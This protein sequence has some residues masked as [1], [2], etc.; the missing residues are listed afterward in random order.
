MCGSVGN[1][2][3]NKTTK[4]GRGESPET[5]SH[6]QGKPVPGLLSDSSRG[7]HGVDRRDGSLLRPGRG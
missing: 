4:K 2:S 5:N 7:G 1:K 3:E 6:N